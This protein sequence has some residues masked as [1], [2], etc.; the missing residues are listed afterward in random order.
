M[1]QF[2]SQFFSSQIFWVCVCFGVLWASMHWWIVPRVRSIQIIR[3]TQV[4]DIMEEARH[5][6]EKSTQIRAQC[7]A[8]QDALEKNFQNQIRSLAQ[9]QEKAV[10]QHLLQLKER[11]DL[12]LS[13]VKEELSRLEHT[14]SE[15][16][17]KDAIDIA[18]VLIQQQ[19]EKNHG[20]Q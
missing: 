7:D 4:S 2:D 18:Q 15:Q 6:H 12:E 10:T 5:L 11:F 1:P 3:S 19:K 16:L 17:K 9:T 13:K 20:N 8:Q 14:F